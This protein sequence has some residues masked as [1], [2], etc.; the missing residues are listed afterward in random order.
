MDPCDGYVM[1]DRSELV[2]GNIGKKVLGASKAGLFYALIRDNSPQ[3]A[4]SVM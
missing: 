2:C 3:I 4:A 1:F